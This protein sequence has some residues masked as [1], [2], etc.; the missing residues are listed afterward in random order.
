MSAEQIVLDFVHA[1]NRA[2]TVGHDAEQ[3]RRYFHRDMVAIVPNAAERLIGQDA[4]VAG[5]KSFMD[6][7][8][9][10]EWRELEPLAQL[11]AD[12]RCAVVTYFYDMRCT[13]NGLDLNLKGRDMLTLIHENGQWWLVADQ[14]SPFPAA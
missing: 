13:M 8:V 3:L 11:Y 7:A 1:M 6:S 4:C 14:F 10:H 12:G 5:W 9:I 2:W